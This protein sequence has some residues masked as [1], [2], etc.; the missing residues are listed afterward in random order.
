MSIDITKPSD[1]RN[2]GKVIYFFPNLGNGFEN[3][4]S[5]RALAQK[6]IDH[7]E[8]PFFSKYAVETVA[9]YIRFALVGTTF[10]GEELKGLL[11]EDKYKEIYGDKVRNG[12]GLAQLKKIN[13]YSKWEKAEEDF[14]LK[15]Y[16]NGKTPKEISRQYSN[17]GDFTPRTYDA[18]SSF[19][20]HKRKEGEIGKQ[21]KF[22]DGSLGDVA[23]GLL[24]RY[25]KDTDYCL[26]NTNSLNE[27]FFGGEE[28]IS[29]QKSHNFY[30]REE[31][32]LEKIILEDNLLAA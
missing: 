28:V 3:G 12:E 8:K 31:R 5:L 13:G 29:R 11:G 2:A 22:W 20:D 23:L 14:V 18:I 15:W 21:R 30:R 27:Y 4:L 17:M 6:I 7:K 19:L 9:K 26:K 25:G 16:G 10:R 24:A 32:K 1:F